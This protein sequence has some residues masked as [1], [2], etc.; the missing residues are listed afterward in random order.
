MMKGLEA[1]GEGG[2]KQEKA[3]QLSRTPL[4]IANQSKGFGDRGQVTAI[5]QNKGAAPNGW[6]QQL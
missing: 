4:S 3:S 2:T 6:T 5:F 1:V